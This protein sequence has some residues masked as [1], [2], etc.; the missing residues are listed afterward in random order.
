MTNDVKAFLIVIAIYI[1]LYMLCDII[2][3]IVALIA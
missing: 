1:G 2:G 3:Y